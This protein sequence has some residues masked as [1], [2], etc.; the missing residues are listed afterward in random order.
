MQKYGSYIG[1]WRLIRI[2]IDKDSYHSTASDHWYIVWPIY[3]IIKYRSILSV[4]NTESK[5]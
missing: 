3:T 5:P 1:N 2:E 4:N